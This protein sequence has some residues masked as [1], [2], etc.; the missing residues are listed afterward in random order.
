MDS[1]SAISTDS[2]RPTTVSMWFALQ[3][4]PSFANAVR[5]RLLIGPSTYA[6]EANPKYA[7]AFAERKPE[8]QSLHNTRRRKVRGPMPL[9]TLIKMVEP[10]SFLHSAGPQ[11][12]IG[13]SSV[14]Q[15]HS[16]PDPKYIFMCPS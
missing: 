11:A 2:G 13:R 5:S 8:T 12:Q 7:I 10:H 15:D 4:L 14:A 6:L 3:G 9:K 16:K 1:C